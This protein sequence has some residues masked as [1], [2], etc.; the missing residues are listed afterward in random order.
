M[1]LSEGH[2]RA[3]SYTVGKC[4]SEVNIVRQRLASR[5]TTDTLLL[6]MA[7]ASNFSAKAGKQLQT[8]IGRLE[9][10]D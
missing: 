6:Q 2:T 10:S 7:I 4:W 8:L 1:L 5:R 3:M 9:E